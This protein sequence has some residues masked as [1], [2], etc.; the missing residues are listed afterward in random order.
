MKFCSRYFPVNIFTPCKFK[1]HHDIIF[2]S[3][4]ANLRHRLVHQRQLLDIWFEQRFIF[5]SEPKSF[6]QKSQMRLQSLWFVRQYRNSRCPLHFTT[7]CSQWKSLLDPLVLVVGLVSFVFCLRSLQK[8]VPVCSPISCLPT[9]ST[10]KKT[11]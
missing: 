5:S 8:F 4:I 7:Q 10:Y 3:V 6:S 2:F 1:L 11:W 9:Q